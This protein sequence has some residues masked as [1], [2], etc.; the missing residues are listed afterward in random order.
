MS[1]NS[2]ASDMVSTHM[3][4][5]V[6]TYSTFDG[7]SR[8]EYFYVAHVDAEEGDTCMLTQYAYDGTSSRI[9]KTKESKA[10]WLAAWEI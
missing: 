7:S 1:I 10:T 5:T 4:E 9:V 8:L 2:H 6:K 3:S